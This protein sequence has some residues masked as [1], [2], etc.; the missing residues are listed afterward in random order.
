[1]FAGLY[2]DYWGRDAAIFR[3]M[4]RLAHIRTEHDDERLLKGGVEE[5]KVCKSELKTG[6]ELMR[7]WPCFDNSNS[8]NSIDSVLQI[9]GFFISSVLENLQYTYNILYQNGLTLL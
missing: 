2:S 6:L 5:K 8:T 1:M 4:G 3:S 9:S 7:N